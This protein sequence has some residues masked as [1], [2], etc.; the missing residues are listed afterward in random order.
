[1]ATY[2]PPPGPQWILGDVFMREYYTVFNYHDKTVGFAKAVNDD[3]DNEYD[4]LGDQRDEH[5]CLRSA[6]YSWCEHS[7]E[8]HRPWEVPCAAKTQILQ[9]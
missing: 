3:D 8:C 2:V 5:G 4:A 1:M 7:N 6:G 9:K